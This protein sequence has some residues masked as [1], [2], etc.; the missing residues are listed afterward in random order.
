M[1]RLVCLLRATEMVQAL[2]QPDG[3]SVSGTLN[4]HVLRPLTRYTPNV[5]K[6][7]LFDRILKYSLG[8]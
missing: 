1:D 6:K 3:G 2:G 4:T 5:I 7:P 8:M